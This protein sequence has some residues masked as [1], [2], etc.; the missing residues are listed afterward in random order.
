MANSKPYYIYV[1]SN[2]ASG[3]STFINFLKKELGNKIDSYCE[4][5]EQWT[6]CN[7]TN[8][9]EDM[10][11]DPKNKSFILQTFIQLTMAKIQIGSTEKQVKIT[12]R[13]L[14]SERFIFIQNLIDN[15]MIN[16]TEFAILDQWFAFLDS[17]T[18]QVD[19]IIYLRTDPR[20]SFSR[21]TNRARLEENSTS[22]EYLTQI[23]NLHEDWLIHKSLGST[24]NALVRT[25]DL[26]PNLSDLTPIY[27]DVAEHIRT[28]LK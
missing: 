1:E 8:L 14:L 27:L 16:S 23:H 3:K 25:I 24:K 7:G 2:I 22:L 17:L 18:P 4:P 6:N 13:S 28:K 15:E 26:S 21:L 10:Y 20:V 19:E 9:L 11:K 5:I 12:E